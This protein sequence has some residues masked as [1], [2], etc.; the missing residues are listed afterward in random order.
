MSDPLIPS[1]PDGN[2]GPQQA[3]PVGAARVALRAAAL[4]TIAVIPGGL[5]HRLTA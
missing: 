4:I 3:G 1:R 2:H 5:A